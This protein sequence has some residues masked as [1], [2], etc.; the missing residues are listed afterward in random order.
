MNRLELCQSNHKNI[1][2]YNVF[3]CTIISI[4]DKIILLKFYIFI[5]QSQI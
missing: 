1:L 3:M 5:I 4:Y 2:K